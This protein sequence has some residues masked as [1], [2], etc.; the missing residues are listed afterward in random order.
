MSYLSRE[1]YESR[2]KG[3]KTQTENSQAELRPLSRAW[4]TLDNPACLRS[5]DA[6]EVCKARPG[7][8]GVLGQERGWASGL[9]GPRAVLPELFAGGLGVGGPPHLAAPGPCTPLLR[10]P[11]LQPAFL[12]AALR[13]RPLLDSLTSCVS[14]TPLTSACTGLLLLSA[15]LGW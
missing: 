13:R 7:A 12:K 4:L 3:F 14:M 9:L 15:F 11:G 10:G 6:C 2:R 1:T 5:L 8:G